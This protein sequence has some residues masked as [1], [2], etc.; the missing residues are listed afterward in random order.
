MEVLKKF[1]PKYALV[2]LIL[3]KFFHWPKK[4]IVSRSRKCFREKSARPHLQVDFA[5][6]CSRKTRIKICKFHP[7]AE[8]LPS[9]RPKAQLTQ[10]VSRALDNQFSDSKDWELT[11]RHEMVVKFCNWIFLKVLKSFHYFQYVKTT[12]NNVASLKMHEAETR[13]GAM[14]PTAE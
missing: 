11:K 7:P 12:R 1:Q 10:R 4:N 5:E 14:W 9:M 2:K 13:S 6:N 3:P 8:R